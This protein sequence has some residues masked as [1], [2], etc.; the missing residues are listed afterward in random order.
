M[1]IAVTLLGVV[2]VLVGMA[3]TSGARRGSVREWAGGV[4]VLT[5]VLA[6]P[7]AAA[8]DALSAS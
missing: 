8:L 6:I 5:S 3:V 2:G 4:L 7:V 1:V